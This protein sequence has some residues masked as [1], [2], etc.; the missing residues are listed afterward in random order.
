MKR[1]PKVMVCVTRQKTCE[2][3]IKIGARVAKE[4]KH[5]I[6]VVHVVKTGENFLGDPHEGEALD[7]LFR[8]SKESGADMTV[9][10]SENVLDTLIEYAKKNLVADIVLGESPQSKGEIN[11]IRDMEK[12]LPNVK[13]RIIPS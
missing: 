7:Y 2:R 1:V 3:L 8:I 12:N 11:I 9:L 6:S 13:F 10:R 5:G 4:S